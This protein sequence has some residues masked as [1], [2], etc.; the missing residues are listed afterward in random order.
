MISAIVPIKRESQRIPDKNFKIINKKPLFFWVIS[1]LSKSDYIDEIV[2]NCDDSY[3]EEKLSEYFDFL[4]F[5]YRPKNLIGNEISM[6]KI[7]SSTLDG[8][9]NNSIFQTHTTNPLLSVKTINSAIKQHIDNNVDYFAVTKL[10]ERL[11]DKNVNPINHEINKLIQ[12]Q[13][14]EPFYHENSGFYVFSKNNFRKNNNRISSNSKFYETY[15]PENIDIDDKR[16]FE[17]AEKALEE[18]E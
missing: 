11:Y 5:V 7:I 14:L 12:T 2:I 3:T 15:F 9:K 10:H 18:T 16:D 6:N 1:S 8:C 4:K 13:D 17:I